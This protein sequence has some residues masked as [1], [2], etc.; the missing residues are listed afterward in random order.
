MAI[1]LVV[2]MEFQTDHAT[3]SDLAASTVGLMGF[4]LEAVVDSC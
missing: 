1:Q 4:L 3:D 2:L